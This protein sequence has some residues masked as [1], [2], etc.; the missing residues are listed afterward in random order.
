MKKRL[1][2]LILILVL[3][4]GGCSAPREDILPSASEETSGARETD[5]TEAYDEKEQERFLTFTEELFRTE[6]AANTV[7]LHYTLAYPEEYGITGYEAVLPPLSREQWEESAASAQETLEELNSFRREAL[8]EDNRL[9]YDVLKDYLETSLSGT[10]FYHFQE[11][12]SPIMGEQSNLP[13]VFAEYTFRR[14]QDVTDYLSLLEQVP[15]YIDSLITLEE[16]RARQ[17][18]GM[19]DS[20]IAEVISGIQEFLSAGDGNIFLTSFEE[21]IQGLEELSDARKQEYISRNSQIVTGQIFP[22]FQRIVRCLQ[23]VRGAAANTQGLCYTENGEAYYE[24]LIRSMTGSGHSPQELTALVEDQIQQ[25]LS[26]MSALLM[27]S[28]ELLDSINAGITEDRSPEEILDD[29]K[30][31]LSEDYP[32]LPTEASYQIKYV[33]EYMESISSP[34]FYMIPPIDSLEENTIYINSSLTDESSLFSTLAHEG[35]PG[36]LYQTVYASCT[37]G[38]PIR[39]LLDYNGYSEGWG[40]YVEHESYAMNHVLTDQSEDLAQLWR[41]NS[42]VTIAVHALLDLK[43][44]YE[45]CTAEQAG[46]I[47]ASYFGEM[48]ESAVQE[49][50]D[51]IVSEPAYYLKYYGGYLEFLL[52]REKAE[53]S[54]ESRFDLKEFHTFLLD[55]GP[56]SF[57][58]LDTYL[59][60]WIEEQES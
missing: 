6:L 22:C 50:Y 41:L 11:P 56:C 2:S 27:Q 57:T 12:F 48:D 20:S 4:L 9:T 55:M 35:Y 16:E 34:A 51:T 26:E 7:N 10:D 13:V 38:N 24:Y 32:A 53:D 39:Q 44:H 8:D 43:I 1:L 59:D 36:H 52:L 14:E 58:T 47:I 46:Q 40:L 33:P 60:Q 42:S 49:F 23:Q 18:L 5:S 45:G 28:P 30:E 29:L 17:G 15:A 54:L 37:M 31:Q 25:D 19:P 3:V 21:R